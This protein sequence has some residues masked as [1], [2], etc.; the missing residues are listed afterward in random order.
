MSYS[1]SKLNLVMSGGGIKGIAYVGMH[2]VA[3]RRGYRWG[4][5]AGV[6]AGALAGAFI[7]SGMNA[8]EMWNSMQ[9]LDFKGIKMGNITQKVPAVERYMEFVRT[10]GHS[11]PES[12]NEFLS[13]RGN[14]LDTVMILSKEGSLFDGDLLEEWTSKELAAKGVRTFA[15]LRDGKIDKCNP[16]GYKMRMTG[17]DLNRAKLVVLPDDVEF[18]GMDPDEFEVAKAIRISTSVPFAFKPVELKKYEGNSVKTYNVVDGGVFDRFPYWLIDNSENTTV[19][20]KLSG[21]EKPKFFSVDTALGVLKTLISA[22]QDIGVPQN[23]ENNIKFIGEI[24]T[25]KVHYLDFDL[26][27]EEKDYLF[28]AGRQTA[29][30]TFNKLEHNRPAFMRSLLS[31]LYP[32]LWRRK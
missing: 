28:N 26:S 17:V 13:V 2:E 10:T 9:R 15:D 23:V 14:L 6:S 24:D 25:T 18:Y 22:V 12:I 20:F 19:G 4:N 7:A 27:S 16:R 11:G 31:M 29:I 30:H 1:Q 3:G 5:M 21:G 8:Y 32:Q